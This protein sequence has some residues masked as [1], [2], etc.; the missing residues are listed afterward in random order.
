MEA[1]TWHL[2]EYRCLA[3]SLRP[4]TEL[5]W[6]R[7]PQCEF[8]QRFLYGDGPAQVGFGSFEPHRFVK[9]ILSAVCLRLTR[10]SNIERSTPNIE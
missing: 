6:L 3:P 2:P 10:T 9:Q 7:S 5:H 4:V 1:E 8:G